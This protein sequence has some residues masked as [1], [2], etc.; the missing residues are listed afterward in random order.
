M[1]DRSSQ[2]SLQTSR[3]NQT[4]EREEGCIGHLRLKCNHSQ[5]VGKLVEALESKLEEFWASWECVGGTI[6]VYDGG[7]Q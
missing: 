4:N 7:S 2:E 6:D 5:D 3:K 1:R